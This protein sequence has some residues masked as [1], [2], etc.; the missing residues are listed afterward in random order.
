MAPEPGTNII[1]TG[2]ESAS[3]KRSGD[4]DTLQEKNLEKIYR[5]HSK[6]TVVRRKKIRLRA[7][8]DMQ[9]TTHDASPRHPEATRIAAV[10]QLVINRK[11]RHRKAAKMIKRSGIREVVP[12]R[13]EYRTHE[14]VLTAVQEQ[15]QQL[16]EAG[17]GLAPHEGKHLRMSICGQKSLVSSRCNAPTDWQSPELSEV[18]RVRKENDVPTEGLAEGVLSP[19]DAG[20]SSPTHEEDTVKGRSA[21]ACFFD[22]N[23]AGAQAEQRKW[24]TGEHREDEGKDPMAPPEARGVSRGLGSTCDTQHETWIWFQVWTVAASHFSIKDVSAALLSST[25]N[26]EAQFQGVVTIPHIARSLLAAWTSKS[27][28][29]GIVDIASQNNYVSPRHAMGGVAV[30]RDEKMRLVDMVV[31]ASC[32]AHKG[33]PIK[34]ITPCVC[35]PLLNAAN[36]AA[37]RS[38]L[39]HR[40]WRGAASESRRTKPLVQTTLSYRTLRSESNES[41]DGATVESSQRAEDNRCPLVQVIAAWNRSEAD[42]YGQCK[43]AADDGQYEG[44]LNTEQSFRCGSILEC[45]V[46]GQRMRLRKA[47]EDGWAYCEH[48]EG[49]VGAALGSGYIPADRLGAVTQELPVE[50]IEGSSRRAG[51]YSRPDGRVDFEASRD[52]VDS[53]EPPPS[54]RLLEHARYLGLDWDANTSLVE[55]GMQQALYT[56]MEESMQA[57][58]P[59]GWEVH[60]GGFIDTWTG[61]KSLSHPLDGYYRQKVADVLARQC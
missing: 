23:M 47:F 40:H 59:M 39:E 14:Q 13:G 18:R 24:Q 54:T 53:A 48:V 34:S 41:L 8:H 19:P 22:K 17:N 21:R 4:V 36:Q 52:A 43:W 46:V 30:D 50:Y 32:F 16:G 9:T 60:D 57:P 42:S 37:S 5:G 56:L 7:G 1:A 51:Q 61:R 25:N 31:N 26:P 55:G 10:K 58:L 2:Q 27:L 15:V 38:W 6:N 33:C 20:E 29:G 44:T 3:S 35:A 11:K 12:T 28:P 49:P 45:C